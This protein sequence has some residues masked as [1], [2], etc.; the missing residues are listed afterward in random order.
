MPAPFRL[1][2]PAPPDSLTGRSAAV[3]A[4]LAT[5]FG[6]W[7]APTF[8]VLSP[9][10]DLLAA[11]WAVLRESLL[12][13]RASRTAKELVALGVS[14]ANRCP[15]CV[16]AH[17]VL[18]H[19]TGDHRLAETAARGGTPADPEHAALLAWGRATRTGLGPDASG[20]AADRPF[21]DAAAPEFV[22]TALAFHFIN[23]MV[24]ALLGDDM[25]P[26]GLQRL[27]VVRSAGGRALARTVRRELRPGESLPL[28]R[29]VPAGRPPYWAGDAPVGT[30]FAALRTA[31][32][33]GGE[34]LGEQAREAVAAAVDA[35]DGSHP[36]LGDGWITRW[37]AALPAGR[38]P[39]A[40]LVLLAALAPYRITEADAEAWRAADPDPYDADLVRLL[41]FGAHLAVSR[42]ETSIQR[43]FQRA[44]LTGH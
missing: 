28:L 19:A 30:A 22:G 42:I 4:Q 11:T 34:R 6:V 16:D 43:P 1:T 17:T 18:L 8:A 35:W 10:P 24:S 15:F 12:A 25:M 26:A 21:D 20:A 29:G 41:A 5:D 14:Q 31:A 36:P 44:R 2:T 37:T 3:Y 23:R 33:R 38:R 7:R 32:G 27:R 39:A 13:G 40:R 9:A